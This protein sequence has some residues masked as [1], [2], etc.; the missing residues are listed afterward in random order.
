MVNSITGLIAAMLGIYL[1]YITFRRILGDSD[2]PNASIA[3][4]GDTGSFSF[5]LS[6]SWF[7]AAIAGLIVG[8]TWPMPRENPIITGALV[9]AIVAHWIYERRERS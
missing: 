7:V 2:D 3:A 6:G 4:S 8:L 5:L 1:A 9:L